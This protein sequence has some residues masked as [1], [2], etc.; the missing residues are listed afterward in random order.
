VAIL[1][2]VALAQGCDP[3]RDAA[4]KTGESQMEE[5][6]SELIRADETFNQTVNRDGLSSWSSFFAPDGAVIQEG[7]GEIRGAQAV[8]ESMDGAVAAGFRSLTWTPERAEVSK[9]GD[10]G[11]TVGRFR[12]VGIGPDGI[13][14]SRTGIYVSIWRRQEDGQ[15]KVE[16]D[17]GNPLTP[18]EPTSD[19]PPNPQP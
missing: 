1:T 6:R 11:Y 14:T 3:S 13:E 5:W 9:G 15:W 17:L 10:L 2:V 16:M 4:L 19:Q 18:A 7:V 8:Q 12:A